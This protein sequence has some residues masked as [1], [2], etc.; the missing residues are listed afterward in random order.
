MRNGHRILGGLVAALPIVGFLA[1]QGY[2]FVFVPDTD[3]LGLHLRF[4]V[5]TPSKADILFVIDNS[6]S[7]EEE[8]EALKSSIGVL[9]GELAPKD[10]S[11]RIGVVSTDRRGFVEACNGSV[12]GNDVPP[13][14]VQKAKGPCDL[15]DPHDVIYPLRRPHDGATGRLLAA[16]NPTYFDTSQMGAT[17]RQAQA[18]ELLVPTGLDSGP[19]DLIGEPGVRWVIDRDVIQVEACGA[20]TCEACDADD[21]TDKCCNPGADCFDGCAGPVASSMV[22]AYFKSNVDGLGISGQ[23]WEE[24]IYN[25]LMAV[26]IDP[27]QP[28][29]EVALDPFINTLREGGPNRYLGLDAAGEPVDQSWI[30]AEALLAIMFV[31]DEQDCSMHE[32]LWSSKS[33]F[34][35]DATPAE[36]AGSVCYQPDRASDLLRLQRM[37]SLLGKR[38]G[39]QEG[40]VAKGRV[41]L[42]FIGGVEKTGPEGRE[43]RSGEA[44]DCYMDGSGGP[45]DDCACL[46]GIAN[47][48]WCQYTELKDSSLHSC[49][50]FSGSRYV[51]FA[52]M[53]SR[54]TFETI[55]TE[56]FG[57][58]MADFATIATL[59]CFDLDTDARPARNNPDLMKVYYTPKAIAETGGGAVLLPRTEENSLE[60]GWYYDADPEAPKICLTALDRL[61]G[62]VYDIFVLVNDKQDFSAGAAED[63]AVAP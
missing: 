58:A 40:Q 39:G 33:G 28:T 53:F 56:S 3:R 11:Y 36:P 8:Q 24:G 50:A 45:K 59:A 12:F 29:D 22:A 27:D 21:T 48:K 5:E 17:P 18:L 62:D 2:D 7:M 49:D 9:L 61:V 37:A 41:A 30:R 46:T 19:A 54:R 20:C 52:R 6:N 47:D 25:G 44:T 34:E 57:Q 35:E 16:Y 55:C 10:T 38:K 60:E 4:A 32:V 31:S 43:G 23:G 42:G 14:G 15:V 1:C 26:G 63:G 51:D 13:Q